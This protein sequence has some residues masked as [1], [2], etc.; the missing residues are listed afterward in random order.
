MN[1]DDFKV[2]TIV[3]FPK[4]EIFG[5]YDAVI[6]LFGQ[7]LNYRDGDGHVIVEKSRARI[8]MKGNRYQR[9]GQEYLKFEKFR[10][11]VQTGKI[12]Q[13]KL[14]NLFQGGNEPFE[15]VA[16]A[17]IQSNSEFM[18]ANVYPSIEKYLGDILTDIANGIV[19]KA[20]FDELFPQ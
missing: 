16:N 11:K 12:K 19:D 10:I 14:S 1:L 7:N 17:F 20:T 18:L 8:A 5:K 13:M 2:D 4:L 6:K 9:D 15:E 3:T